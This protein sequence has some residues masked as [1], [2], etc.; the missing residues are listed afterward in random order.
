MVNCTFLG[1]VCLSFYSL[2]ICT[3][4]L[5]LGLKNKK[6]YVSKIIKQH[7][8]DIICLQ[9]T[10]VE[11]NYPQNILSFKGYDYLT[12]NNSIKARTGMYINNLIPYQRRT[13]LEKM[14]CGII[15]VDVQLIRFNGSFESFKIKCKQLL[16]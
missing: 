13:D 15:I 7:K 12:E 16:L 14:D 9:E 5:C 10:D 3:W 8:L 11:L 2:Y 6:D 1:F 4:N